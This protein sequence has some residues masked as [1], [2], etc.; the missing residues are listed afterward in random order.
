MVAAD[1][2]ACPCLDPNCIDCRD[3]YSVHTPATNCEQCI[4]YKQKKEKQ[5]K[6]AYERYAMEQYDLDRWHP[7]DSALGPSPVIWRQAERKCSDA[8]VQT[9]LIDLN[10]CVKYDTETNAD[11]TPAFEAT[12]K[13]IYQ[14]PFHMCPRNSCSMRKIHGVYH[15]TTIVDGRVVQV[16]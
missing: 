3:H 8:A 2:F 15:L 6:E 9:P 10:E 7:F 13:R 14:I 16:V 11:V 12:E 5:S 4:R 1:R